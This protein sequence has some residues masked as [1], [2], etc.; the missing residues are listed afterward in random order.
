MR[1]CLT[2]W[3]YT[4]IPV[5]FT[6][7]S[8]CFTARV[9]VY[10]CVFCVVFFFFAY[11]IVPVPV[12][13][14]LGLTQISPGHELHY[15][16][17]CIYLDQQC[18]MLHNR[19]PKQILFSQLPFGLRRKSKHRLRFIFAI[20]RRLKERN[21]KLKFWIK[22]LQQKNKQITAVKLKKKKKLCGMLMI[23]SSF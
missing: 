6:F 17:L 22:L 4:C 9:C 12:Y 10:V 18:I 11:G 20:K 8:L 13:T 15:L 19:I 16:F 7:L 1:I 3:Q 2:S 14:W 5:C 23:T 21:I